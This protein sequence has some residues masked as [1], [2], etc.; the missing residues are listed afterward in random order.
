MS[1]K[2]EIMAAAR[3]A[4]AGGLRQGQL[5]RLALACCGLSPGFLITGAGAGLLGSAGAGR[6][7]LRSQIA[8]QLL[9]LVWLRF[10]IIDGAPLPRAEA[11]DGDGPPLRGAVL[12]VLGVGGWMALFGALGGVARALVG[13]EAEAG[14]MG[15]LEVSSGAR[16]L[17]ALPLPAAP[18][19]ALLSAVMGFGGVCVGLQNLAALEG[20]GVSR[21]RYF[22]TRL[23]AAALSAGFTWLQQAVAP[24][25]PGPVPDPLRL[26]CLSMCAVALPA[27]ILLKRTES[28]QTED[29]QKP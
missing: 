29:G 8:C 10:I 1:F 19:L 9:L 13:R 21:R 5:E 17:C 26:G 27:L 18:R 12:A 4:R 2:A 25:A 7:L 16:A 11:A 22:L 23:L 20:L 15:L 6:V 3:A 28:L 14:L 24:G